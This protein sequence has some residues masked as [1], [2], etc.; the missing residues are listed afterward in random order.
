VLSF[1]I[2]VRL[3]YCQKQLVQTAL[4]ETH[5]NDAWIVAPIIGVIAESMARIGSRM[6]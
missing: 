2:A 1:V 5:Q 6:T 4:M 3:Y